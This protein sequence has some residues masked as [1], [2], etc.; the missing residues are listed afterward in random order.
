M[1]SIALTYFRPD[2]G[3]KLLKECLKLFIEKIWI[4]TIKDRSLVSEEDTKKAWYL[5]PVEL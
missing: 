1:L 3:T 2:T 4:A 5:Q